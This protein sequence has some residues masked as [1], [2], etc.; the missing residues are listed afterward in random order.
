MWLLL[1]SEI[2][3][4]TVGVSGLVGSSGWGGETAL[5]VLGLGCSGELW[6]NLASFSSSD[7]ILI[8]FLGPSVWQA[9]LF[10]DVAVLE[11]SWAVG[12][13]RARSRASRAPGVVGRDPDL[14]GRVC[15]CPLLLLQ[16][17]LL[18]D[19]QIMP[20]STESTPKL[21]CT[22]ALPVDHQPL[23]A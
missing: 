23:P 9:F 14:G 3:F 8:I 16:F 22:L 18:S 2:S 12:G 5:E 10:C 13:Y 7:S 15:G 20:C 1:S 17:S 4:P 19:M 21:P 6:A 11:N